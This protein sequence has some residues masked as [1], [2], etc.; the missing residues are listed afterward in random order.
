MPGVQQLQVIKG[1]YVE[2]GDGHT[3]SMCYVLDDV[4]VGGTKSHSL[5]LTIDYDAIRGTRADTALGPSSIRLRIGTT[6]EA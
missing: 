6:A 3:L 5:R 1:V 4:H 2:Y